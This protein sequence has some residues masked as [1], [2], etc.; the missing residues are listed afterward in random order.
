M[1]NRFYTFIV[2]FWMM[3]S[4]CSAQMLVPPRNAQVDGFSLI[5][6][7]DSPRIIHLSE[8][9]ESATFPPTG[10]TE[11]SDGI[12]WLQDFWVTSGT[13]NVPYHSYFAVAD[14]FSGSIGI[15][16][17]WENL[18]TPTMDL[19]TVSSARLR[20]QSY[21]TGA[22]GENAYV[23]ISSNSGLS[24]TNICIPV[25][26]SNW[27]EYDIN[28]SA[29]CGTPGNTSM[30]LVF[31][32]DR[33]GQSGSGWAIDNVEVYTPVS[34]VLSYNCFLDD[35]LLQITT[36]TNYYIL[37]TL[38]GYNE[39]HSFRVSANYAQGTSDNDTAVFISQY[40]PPPLNLTAVN[41]SNLVIL[42]WEIPFDSATG[43]VPANLLNF[44][45]FQDN[46]QLLTV[47]A[48][49]TSVQTETLPG[50]HTYFLVAVYDLTP[51]GLPGQ[52]AESIYSNIATD[53]INYGYYFPF[54]ENWDS[55]Q[56]S[57]Q[58]WNAEGGWEIESQS[59]NPPPTAFFT[60]TPGKSTY[61]RSLESYWI[62]A[63]S[64]QTTT[65]YSII[66]EYSIK[67]NKPNSSGDVVFY[68]DVWNGESWEIAKDYWDINSFEWKFQRIDIS[69]YARHHAFKF[70]FRATGTYTQ[71]TVVWSID[72]I[73]V[74]MEPNL[75]PPTDLYVQWT[76]NP[77]ND[78]LITWSLPQ[79]SGSIMDYILDDNSAENGWALNPGY[80]AWLG[81]EFDILDQASLTSVD[82]NWQINDLAG[83]EPLSIDIF[84]SN[85]ELIGTSD[86]FYPSS[87]SW[88]NINLPSIN[89]NGP[90]YA[91]VHWNLLAGQTNYLSSDEN[92]PN[93]AMDLGWYYDGIYWDHLSSFGYVPCVFL[94]RVHALVGQDNYVILAGEDPI[95]NNPGSS[96]LHAT[97]SNRSVP[98]AGTTPQL[99][100]S[101]SPCELLGF[102]IYRMIVEHYFGVNDTVSPWTLIGSTAPN[103]NT[104]LDND[105]YYEAFFNYRV[106]ANYTEGESVPSN[107]DWVIRSG[108][109]EAGKAELNIFPNP[110]D[111]KLSIETTLEISDLQLFNASGQM[112]FSTRQEEKLK[113]I[114]DVS[115]FPNGIYLL[116][117]NGR[118]EQYCRKLIISH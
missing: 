46:Q 18:Y 106:T 95:I 112:V 70:R 45:V 52:Q 100:P 114:L 74:H 12:G 22:Y 65:P 42:N 40:L 17:V 83:Y 73:N 94:L 54:V 23:K 35:S 48:Q 56:F 36:L 96:E 16:G 71:D 21:Y 24:W 47:S 105:L 98:D 62:N 31:H 32:A 51:F 116:H 29:F 58:N 111:K 20:F 64:I 67:L 77:N 49:S 117:M 39:T 15:N 87:D 69:Y 80:N 6:K 50:I 101:D 61:E 78:A 99:P 4:L 55:Q 85:H 59:G 68:L 44:K 66:L 3:Q 53:T 91:M 109:D 30:S 90:F 60:G 82:L 79:G 14:D 13:F 104:Y 93:A 11:E 41:D 25:P 57:N 38:V 26:D 63:A 1:Q 113:Y 88:Q 110:A 27:T 2:A 107:V 34:G 118:N 43:S 19:S 28:L 103:V 33:G 102:N 97:A 76:G 37:P 9:F 86:P 115:N 89:V 81:N 108:I 72:N 5:A 92:G 7:W 10:W 8:D 84:N 75:F